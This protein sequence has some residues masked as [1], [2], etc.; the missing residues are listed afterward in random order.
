MP[1]VGAMASKRR[2]L[3]A[4]AQAVARQLWTPSGRRRAPALR[5]L[6]AAIRRLRRGELYR[7][8]ELDPRGPLYLLVTRELVR[9]LAARIRKLGARRV[10]EVAAGD[11]FLSEELQRVAPDLEIVASDSGGWVDPRARMNARE[12]RELSGLPVPG[13]RLG[14]SVLRVDALAAIRR[15]RPD[16]VLASW[17]PPND[18][19]A[20]LIRTKVRYVLEIG[21]K[22]AVTPGAWNWRFAHEFCEELEAVARCRLDERPRRE[23]HS[24]VTLYYG[25]SHPEHACARVRR[26]T[27]LWQFRP[28]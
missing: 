20:R 22:D 7:L 17:L 16:L 13:V 8:C 4:G 6:D 11:G 19:L 18:L 12:K 15:T 26:G 10:L 24:R 1:D 3:P 25:R 23:L 21:A 27:W 28:R 14:A 2:R 9:A 5:T